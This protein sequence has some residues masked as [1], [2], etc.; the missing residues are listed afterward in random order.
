MSARENKG[1]FSDG[2]NDFS[3]H[4]VIDPGGEEDFAEGSGKEKE[5]ESEG[6]GRGKERGGGEG[7]GEGGKREG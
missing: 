1:S 6:V 4:S 2:G 7:E 3:S 5:K